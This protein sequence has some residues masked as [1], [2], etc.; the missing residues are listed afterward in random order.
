M[1]LNK[2]KLK[3]FHE[4]NDM[5]MKNVVGGWSTTGDGE[6]VTGDGDCSM[7]CYDG[8][9]ISVS[10]CSATSNCD[11]HGGAQNCNGVS[12]SSCLDA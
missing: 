3:D 7:H 12:G 9:V 1:K 2:L 10:A 8:T 6:G 11:G 4:M 5:E